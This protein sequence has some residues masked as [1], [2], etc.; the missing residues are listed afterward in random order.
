MGVWFIYN[1]VYGRL[2]GTTPYQIFLPAAGFRDA[3]G[4]L[5]DNYS[6]Q[7]G[8]RGFYWG[9]NSGLSFSDRNSLVGGIHS[10]A[11]GGVNIRCVAK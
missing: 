9:S 7:P 3:D 5:R 2:F 10:F 8:I 11:W 1:G 4:N 6:E